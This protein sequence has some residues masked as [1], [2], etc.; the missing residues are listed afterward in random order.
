[1]ATGAML[2]HNRRDIFRKCRRSGSCGPRGAGRQYGQPDDEQYSRGEKAAVCHGITSPYKK[3]I[4]QDYS[5]S[6]SEFRLN[7]ISSGAGL[8]SA[9]RVLRRHG[10]CFWLFLGPKAVGLRSM[11]TN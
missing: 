10:L 9:S 1:M 11:L 3:I 4:A 6:Q 5:D 8:E 2:V 7:L